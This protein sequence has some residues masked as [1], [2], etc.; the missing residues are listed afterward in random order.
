MK[1]NIYRS[2]LKDKLFNF[3]N[4]KQEQGYKYKNQIYGIKAFDDFLLQTN[5]N[6]QLLTMEI[7]DKYTI[8]FQNKAPKSKQNR[9]SILKEFSIYLKMFEDES[10][11]IREN[12][13][14]SQQIKKSYIYSD[15]EINQLLNAFK[16]HQYRHKRKSSLANYTILGVLTFTGLRIQE[17]LNINLSQWDQENQTIFIKEGKF[18]K[19]RLIPIDKSVNDKLKE[20]YK[21]RIKLKSIDEDEPLFINSDLKRVKQNAFRNLFNVKIKELN[22]GENLSNCRDPKIHSLRHSFAVKALLKWVKA[23]KNCND[24]LPYLSTYMGHISL[25]STQVYLQS[26]KE[27]DK[28]EYTKFYQRFKNNI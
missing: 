3:I 21:K 1:N 20:Y 10:Y 11:Q 17:C 6:K 5:Y 7:V 13:F 22:I 28:I 14:R 18:R 25:E 19:D 12:I 16:S 23:G 27:I 15:I 9:F 8:Y 24:M 4:F 26:V 2:I